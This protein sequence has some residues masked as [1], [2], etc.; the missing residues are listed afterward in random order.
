MR[1]EREQEF[2]DQWAAEIR[3]EDVLVDAAWTAVTSPERRWMRTRFGDLQGKDV[4]DLGCGAGEG[5]VWFARQGARVVA[6]DLSPGFLNLVQRTAAYHGV[7]LTT[8]TD[9][10]SVV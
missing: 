6:S 1:L 9:R 2:H 8:L 7:S 5:A 3:P 10:K 4:L